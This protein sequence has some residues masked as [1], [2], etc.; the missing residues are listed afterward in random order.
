MYGP[1]QLIRH[2]RQ[3][4]IGWF[5]RLA[6]ENGVIPIYGDGSQLR[7]FVFVDDAADAFLRAGASDACNGEVFNVGGDQP[8]SHRDLTTELV[9]IAGAGRVE[10]VTWP[11]DKKAIDIGDFYADSSKFVRTTG[12]APTVTL[13]E[14]LKRTVDERMQALQAMADFAEE[15][16]KWRERRLPHPHGGAPCTSIRI[17]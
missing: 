6:I 5:I 16:R 17:P 9:Q 7:D 11:A 13:S 4:F 12:W 14:G 8:I 15:C 1:R 2:N 10:Y 3:G